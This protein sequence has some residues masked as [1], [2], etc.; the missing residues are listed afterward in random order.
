M[1]SHRRCALSLNQTLIL[2]NWESHSQFQSH[3][4]PSELLFSFSPLDISPR[5]FLEKCKSDR[6]VGCKTWLYLFTLGWC[7]WRPLPPVTNLCIWAKNVGF[8]MNDRFVHLHGSFRWRIIFEQPFLYFLTKI[9]LWEKV[10][11]TFRWHLI[12]WLHWQKFC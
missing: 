3:Y 12:D 11:S 8:F 7:F 10:K 4:F 1:D 9:S 5:N 2:E 6:L